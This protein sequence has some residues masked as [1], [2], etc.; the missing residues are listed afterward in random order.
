VAEAP[1][2]DVSVGGSVA[3]H[4]RTGSH[5]ILLADWTFFADFASRTLP[6]AR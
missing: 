5:D 3:Y 2:P 6:P 1:P 4:T